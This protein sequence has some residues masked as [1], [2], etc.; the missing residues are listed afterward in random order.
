MGGEHSSSNILP[1][2]FYFYRGLAL[3]TLVCNFA[4]LFLTL[5]GMDCI[6]LTKRRNPK[7]KVASGMSL[8]SALAG[9]VLVVLFWRNEFLEEVDEFGFGMKL[10]IVVVLLDARVGV[11]CLVTLHDDDEIEY[12][13]T[14]TTERPTSERP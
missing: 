1:L 6:K 4:A 9:I 2:E 8:T 12:L 5:A 7:L 11:L 3:I 13:P 10:A 14:Y